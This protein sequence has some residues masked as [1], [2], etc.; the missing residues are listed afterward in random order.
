[1]NTKMFTDLGLTENESMVYALLLEEGPKNAKEILELT[2]LK[3]GSVYYIL[4]QLE[5]SGLLEKKKVEKKTVFQVTHPKNLH[6]YIQKKQAA[7]QQAENALTTNLPDLVSEYNMAH[8]KPGVHFAEGKEAII[9]MYKE[10][11]AEG[12]E[13]YSIEESGE[14]VKYLEEYTDEYIAARVKNKQH[15]KS[16]APSTNTLNMTDPEKYIET[17]LVDV[18][19]FPFRM[20]VKISGA[21]TMLVTFNDDAAIGVTI[22]NPEIAENFSMLFDLL[23]KALKKAKMSDPNIV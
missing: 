10:F 17:Q 21:K 13:I 19:D 18:K 20:D 6:L 15:N 7:L 2:E 22:D 11:L 1:M 4:E 23:W 16:I 8:Y 9:A 12:E 14:M 3:K 5:L